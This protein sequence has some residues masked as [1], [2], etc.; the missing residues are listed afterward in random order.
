M[1]FN[2]LLSN[3]LSINF[4]YLKDD[5]LVCVGFDIQYILYEPCHANFNTYQWP[6]LM[7]IRKLLTSAWSSQ[8]HGSSHCKRHFHRRPHSPGQKHKKI[9]K[10]EV[11]EFVKFWIDMMCAPLPSWLRTWPLWSDHIYVIYYIPIQNEFEKGIW[12][13]KKRKKHTLVHE[14]T[15]GQTRLLQSPFGVVWLAVHVPSSL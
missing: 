4:I 12:V 10:S 15:S 9:E 2:L 5:L 13:E 6:L 3:K 7:M 14:F 1:C 11:F 8:F